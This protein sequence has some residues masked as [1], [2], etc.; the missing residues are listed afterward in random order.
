MGQVYLR[1]NAVASRYSTTPRNIERMVG[2]GRIPP[3]EFYNGRQPL[4]SAEALEA[5][6][7]R[8]ATRQRKARTA[9]KQATA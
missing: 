6:D 7:R 1:K 4:W 5:S 3:P 2:D 9:D 8:A